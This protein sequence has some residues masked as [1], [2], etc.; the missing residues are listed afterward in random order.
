MVRRKNTDLIP[1][2]TGLPKAS[3]LPSVIDFLC[4]LAAI[5]RCSEM[6]IGQSI[7]HVFD[8]DEIS[9]ISA[10]QYLE[11]KGA[12]HAGHILMNHWLKSWQ[13]FL[14]YDGAR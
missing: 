13:H 11:I 12:A 8:S 2:V 10:C 1:E 5:V 7:P 9:Y 14:A 4:L 6:P 3:D